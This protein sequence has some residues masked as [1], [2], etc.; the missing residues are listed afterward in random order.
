MALILLKLFWEP[1]ERA[2]SDITFTVIVEMLQKWKDVDFLKNKTSYT[3]INEL[4]LKY[5]L[6]KVKGHCYGR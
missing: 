1:E 3:T 6:Q 4:K 5:L 2:T